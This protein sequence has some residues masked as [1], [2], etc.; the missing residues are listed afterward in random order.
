MKNSIPYCSVIVLN[1]FGE[2]V[3]D[4]TI[5]SLLAL[6]YSKDS[7]EIII[8][9]NN[10]SDKSREIILNYTKKYNNIKHLFLD[11]NLG[12]AGGNNE[13]IK[14]AKGEY[15]ALLNNDCVV[16]KSWLHELVKTAE[17]NPNIFAVTSKVVLY[18]KYYYLEF[19]YDNRLF[20]THAYLSN[21]HLSNLEKSNK[22][23]L[24]VSNKDSFYILETPFSPEDKVISVELTFEINSQSRLKSYDELFYVLKDAHLF[25]KPVLLIMDNRIV[26]QFDFDVSKVNKNNAFEKIQ[27]AGIVVFQ[28]GSGRDIGAKIFEQTQYYEFDFGQYEKERQVYAAC[29]AA[30]LYNKRILDIISYLDDSFFMYYEDVEISERARLNGYDIYYAP[31]AVVR[32]LHAFSSKEWSNFFIYQAEKGRL[33]H[34]FFNFPL[35][36][37]IKEYIKMILRITEVGLRVIKGLADHQRTMRFVKST[38]AYFRGS[39]SNEGRRRTDLGKVI[40][41]IK[42]VFYFLFCLPVLITKRI[43]KNKSISQQMIE[44]NYS[45]ILKG[46]WYFNR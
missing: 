6:D 30:V 32:H 19:G 11:K 35:R 45:S 42:V 20:L 18:P 17:K 46:R 34:V 41:Y 39:V 10:S 16:N 29:G 38:I 2:K 26:I 37:F 8:V 40:Q 28:D 22:L 14:I 1:Y 31:K 5:K 12:F 44:K 3:I 27:N 23:K 33:L 21:S 36:I 25:K 15:V 4:S 24:D 9:D 43:R 13:G 7:F